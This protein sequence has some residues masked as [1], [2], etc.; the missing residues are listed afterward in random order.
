MG[1][2]FQQM[3]LRISDDIYNKVTEMSKKT[4]ESVAEVTRKLI[5]KGLASEWVNEN[6]DLI[7]SIVRQQL[8]IVL[9]PHVERLAKLSSKTGHMASTAAFLNVQALQDLVAPEKRKDVVDM[10]NKARKM[11]VGYMKTRTD[12]F[13]TEDL[14]NR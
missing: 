11:A 14:Y 12:D 8:D 7:A 3:H 10:Y 13:D 1:H 4:G 5:E 9:K 6:D 2:S